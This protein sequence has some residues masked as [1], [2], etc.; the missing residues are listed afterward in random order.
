[1]D[2]R[3]SNVANPFQ[4]INF[5]ESILVNQF[6]Q[7]SSLFISKTLPK[8]QIFSDF[9]D[10]HKIGRF[11]FRHFVAFS[12]YLNLTKKCFKTPK[13]LNCPPPPIHIVC[14]QFLFES[15]KQ[16]FSNLTPHLTPPEHLNIGCVDPKSICFCN[17]VL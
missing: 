17:F 13:F 7:F 2:F 10:G 6:Y 12:E 8:V 3:E 5:S 11:F 1:M 16:C 9:S 4:Q 15:R 14:Y